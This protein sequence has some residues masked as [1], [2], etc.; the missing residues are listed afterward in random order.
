MSVQNQLAW[1]LATAP[2]ASLRNGA[3]AR[4][5]AEQASQLSGGDNPVILRTLAA[6]YAEEGNYG[7]A[8]ATARRALELPVAQKN[9]ALAASLQKDRQLY[10]ANTPL[11]DAPR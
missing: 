1:L 9:D 2:D 7:Q 8:V 11:R 4:T 10:Q 5:L 6:A 3:E